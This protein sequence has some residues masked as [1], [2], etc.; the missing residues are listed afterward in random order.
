[1]ND[2]IVNAEVK[3][4]DVQVKDAKAYE[5]RPLVASDMGSICKIITAIGIRQFKE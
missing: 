4:D 3:S 5:L 2:M 1:M